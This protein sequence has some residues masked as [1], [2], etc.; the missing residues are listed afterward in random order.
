MKK[1]VIA[2][3]LI[4]IV[5]FSVGLSVGVFK[6][7]PY[8]QLDSLKSIIL[9]EE[10]STRKYTMDDF[11]Y[12]VD[13]NSLI[14]ISSVDE[15]KIKRSQLIYYLWNQNDLPQEFP[16]NIQQ[17]IDVSLFSDLKNLKQIDLI[18][19]KM[20]FGINSISYMFHPEDS[21]NKI[22]FYH[23]GHGGD[24]I[25]G[26]NTIEFFLNNGYTVQAF[27]MLLLGI[28]EKP[29]VETEFGPIILNSHD[30]LKYLESEKFVPLKLFFEPLVVSLNYLDSHFNFDEYYMV[31][32]SGGAWTAMYYSA[33]DE[34]ISQ[35]YPVAGPYPLFIR[36]NY[37]QI[38]DYETEHPQ[39]LE[40]VNELEA[41]L[42]GSFG[43]DRKFV[44]IY[45]KFDSCCW[46]GEYYKIFESTIKEKVSEFG[47]GYYDVI[48]DDTHH[49]HIISD[50]ALILIKNNMEIK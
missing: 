30:H 8:Y 27:S 42:M 17:N 12:G 22:V 18:E 49:Q 45:N 4:S 34:R 25:K 9:S 33:I 35:T 2:I 16:T 3:I 13:I 28:N 19:H 37:N 46:D 21:N 41:Y 1:L 32:I 10:N 43:K 38:G 15:L 7:F 39:L 44:Q 23:Q 29:I 36:S 6:F 48:I 5:F 50:H 31:G 47:S 14:D 24:F 26:K 11:V 20:E 40:I